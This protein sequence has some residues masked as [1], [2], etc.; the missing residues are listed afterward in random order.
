V[1]FAAPHLWWAMGVRVGFPGG[2]ESYEFFM[3]SAWR[4]AFDVLVVVLSAVMVFIIRS[5]MRPTVP[6]RHRRTLLTF[7]WFGSGLLMLRGVA[8]A[9]ADGTSD[10]VWWPTFLVG[11]ILLGSVAWF[12]RSVVVAR[13]DSTGP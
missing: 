6:S 2:D 8:G 4:Y 10:P 13:S 3:G 11:G 12:G 9:I 1:L 7:A 5:L